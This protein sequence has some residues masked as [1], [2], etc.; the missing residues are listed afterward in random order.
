M[1]NEIGM[2]IKEASPFKYTFII[3]HSNGYTGYLPPAWLYKEGGYEITTTPF[4]IGSAEKVVKQTLDML[5]E[6]K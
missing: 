2:A 4:E 3:T 1:L 5:Y 6:L